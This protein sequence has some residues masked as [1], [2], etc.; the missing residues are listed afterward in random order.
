MTDRMP[1]KLPLRS[2][3]GARRAALLGLVLLAAAGPLLA[4]PGAGTGHS[5]GTDPNTSAAGDQLVPATWPLRLPSQT[6]LRIEVTHSVPL[7]IGTA[8]EGKLLEPVYGPDRMLLAAGLGVRGVIA[9]TPDID[10][11]TRIYARLDGDFTP[12]HQPVIRVTQLVLPS[13][14]VLSLNAV[15][16]MR[17][18]ASVSLAARPQKTSLAGQLKQRVKTQLQQARDTVHS[19]IHGSARDSV[20]QQHPGDRLRRLLYAQLPYHPQRMWAGSSF[21]AVLSEPLLVP[22]VDAAQATAPP[23]APSIDLAS[24]TMHARLTGTVTSEAAAKGD[25]V[26]A[27]LTQPFLDAEGRMML[28]TGTALSGLVVQAQRARWF[29]R[30]GKLRFSFRSIAT[31]S[32]AAV[33]A[34]NSPALPPSANYAALGAD[35]GAASARPQQTAPPERRTSPPILATRSQTA[36]AATPIDGHL[37]SIDALDGENVALDP[38][39]GARAQPDKGRFLAPLALGLL[40]AASQDEDGRGS[41]VRAGV[42]SNGFG[43][44]ARI[45]T[46]ALT[47]QNLSSGFAAYAFSKSVY[48]RWIARG[49]EVTFPKYTELSIDLGRK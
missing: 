18:A 5:T 23:P 4:Q 20:A 45:L 1:G 6:P 34:E 12:L 36:V 27:V 10:R 35:G 16:D 44:P 25:T 13:G 26:Q 41:V 33:A 46:A 24:G 32:A 3:R 47:S 28:P 9:A 43:I 49:H 38:E 31:P 39:G 7:K 40:G 14:A 22:G 8:F 17:A 2:H 30:S 11:T 19:V 21:D 37:H 42:T 15:G 29:G 48:R